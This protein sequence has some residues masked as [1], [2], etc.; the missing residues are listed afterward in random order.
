M[1]DS[2]FEC[3]PCKDGDEVRCDKGNLHTY[4]ATKTYGHVSG[5]QDV[6]T[7]GGYSGSNVVHEHFIIKVPHGLPLEIIGPL[8]YEPLLQIQILEYFR[9]CFINFKFY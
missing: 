7:F 5:N 2:C 9:P 3:D 1:V 6:Q 8:L 4:N